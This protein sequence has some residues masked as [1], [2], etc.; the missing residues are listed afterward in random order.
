LLSKNLAE[1]IV[2]DGIPGAIAFCSE[3]ALPL[4]A[5]VGADSGATLRRASHQARNPKNRANAT[6]L[7]I[8]N[9][10]R[11]ALKGGD[12]PKPQLRKHVDG[13]VPFFAPIV[14]A[15]PLCL[16]CHGAPGQDIGGETLGALRKLYPQDEATGFKLGELR[17]LWRVD[18]RPISISK[19]LQ[20]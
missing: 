4:T 7:E 2:K 3:N 16:K 20:P 6:E 17:G 19:P 18:F 8:L 12:A 9:A 1:A 15:N 13:S 14:L 5:S 10:F 11:D